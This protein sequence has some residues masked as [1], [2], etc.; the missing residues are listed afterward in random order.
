[1]TEGSA[2]A[3]GGSP[4]G[5]AAELAGLRV[6]LVLASSTG[7]VGRHVRSLAGGLIS[8]GARVTVLGPAATG[9][10]FRFDRLGAGFAA[11]EAPTAVRPRAGARAVLRLRRMLRGADV[12]HAHGL[13]AAVLTG[14]ALGK[15]RRE[16]PPYVAT[17]HNA[18]PTAPG[19]SPA[20]A[21]PGAAVQRLAAGLA[22]A[23][24]GVSPDLVERA[25]RMGARGAFFLPIA[26]P[27][28][29]PPSR[30]ASEVREELGAG[31]RPV[32]LAVGRLEPQK[33]YPTLL[34]AAAGWRARQPV[35]LVAVAGTGPLRGELAHRIQAEQLPV[36]LL[37]DRDDVA[38][39]LGAADVVVVSSVWEARSLVAQEA[40]RAGR[41]L[42]ATAVGG[43]P[44]LVGE[45]A[46]LVPPADPGALRDAVA[47]VLDDPAV[48]TRLAAAGPRRAAGWPT[49]DDTV[50]QVVALYRRLCATH[51][52]GR[53][54]RA[55]SPFR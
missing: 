10:R 27:P 12:V 4:N 33:D 9:A 55:L 5:P 16:R 11:V 43:L 54:W 41:P 30:G 17:W 1:M 34:D 48:A 38:D 37:G 13:R 47:Q 8:R 45:A 14:L 31:R 23:T 24:L 25:R 50:D 42:V 52:A 7:G 15:R 36:R 26:A 40:L 39:L 20:G 18:L 46:L 51:R 21:A 28:L 6:T 2:G 32:V 44:G 3:A 35:P 53:R 49:E 22:D 29:R 19:R